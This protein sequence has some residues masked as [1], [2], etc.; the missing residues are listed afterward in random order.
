MH[1]FTY[2]SG[3]LGGGCKALHVLATDNTAW[4]AMLY[5]RKQS[6]VLLASFAL[7]P[8]LLDVMGGVS[9]HRLLREDH[10]CMSLCDCLVVNNSVSLVTGLP[11]T[12]WSGAS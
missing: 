6:F 8:S 10:F 7:Y 2:R 9:R 4:P 12:A 1:D 5:A 3:T 11:S